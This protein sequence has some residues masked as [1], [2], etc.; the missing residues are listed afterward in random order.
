MFVN[1]PYCRS[2][3]TT[4]FTGPSTDLNGTYFNQSLIQIYFDCT[5]IDMNLDTY[6]RSI[7]EK[8]YTHLIQ[9]YEFRVECQETQAKLVK[10]LGKVEFKQEFDEHL[11]V[12]DTSLIET[13]SK[14]DDKS[15][16][17]EIEVKP[18]DIGLP[19]WSDEDNDDDL[20]VSTTSSLS[21]NKKRNKKIKINF[22]RNDEGN[23]C[24]ESIYCN[25]TF[26]T[27]IE[28]SRHYQEMKGNE[29]HQWQCDHCKKTYSTRQSLRG[30]LQKKN[31]HNQFRCQECNGIFLG[32]MSYR[33]HIRKIHKT[34]S[35][36]V[37]LKCG[38]AFPDRKELNF[39][40]K[41][42]HAGEM[43][44]FCH[45]CGRN[46]YTKIN[47]EYHIRVHTQ[48]RPFKCTIEGCEK[49]FKQDGQL[50]RHILTHSSEQNYSCDV[51]G[52]KIKSKYYLN[53]HRK[54][55]FYDKRFKCDEC[56]MTFAR[57]IYI[58]E[59]KKQC[60][61]EDD[62]PPVCPTCGKSFKN[63]KCL[64]V[65]MKTHKE[66]K[67]GCSLCEK[68]FIS[69]HKLNEHITSTHEQ[70]KKCVCR[71]EGCDKAYYRSSHLL[72]HEKVVHKGFPKRSKN[73][74]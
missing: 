54:I 51:C 19:T 44:F 32:K 13:E 12:I 3:G 58:K 4:N 10:R 36:E 20:N 25:A 40:K 11:G 64:T 34:D 18:F 33:S 2:C 74:N 67:F 39:H 46:M 24:C 28:L 66:T 55:H 65:H 50:N 7:C 69:K 21:V 16:A 1:D 22:L 71:F 47:L 61:M 35:N 26:Q 29:T 56:D 30:H 59:H 57:P 42:I 6:S 53:Q 5:N 43:T 70:I 48:E 41:T 8:C 15:I 68:M 31:P 38:K 52:I 49:A 45:I 37:C 14:I 63:Q 17:I 62:I 23:Y 9:S 72:Y 27:S 60:H 73:N